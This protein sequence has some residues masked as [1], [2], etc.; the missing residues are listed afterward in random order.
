MKRI[1]VTGALGQIGSEL[2]P[3][4]R[5][6]YGAKYVVALDLRMPWPDPPAGQGLFEH[7]DCTHLRHYRCATYGIT[8]VTSE[9]LCDYLLPALWR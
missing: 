6:R 3:A 8:K 7:L 4:L 2:V 1:L 9:L 5:V